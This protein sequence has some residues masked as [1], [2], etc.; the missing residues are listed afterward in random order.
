MGPIIGSSSNDSLLC[1]DYTEHLGRDVL[2]TLEG[3]LSLKTSSIFHGECT[4]FVK[5]Q[6]IVFSGLAMRDYG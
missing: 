1:L 5:P 2:Y 3:H 6:E 4:V